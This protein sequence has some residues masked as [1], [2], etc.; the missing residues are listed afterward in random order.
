MEEIT[1]YTAVRRDID[2]NK[3]VNNVIYLELAYQAL[4]KEIDLNFKDIEIYYK[5]QI[6]LDETVKIYRKTENNT[7]IICIKS[8]DERDL[9]A[10]IKF[11]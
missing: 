8:K 3:H 7:H 4:Q 5:K 6:K 2:A 9:H 11:F 1:E 10:I